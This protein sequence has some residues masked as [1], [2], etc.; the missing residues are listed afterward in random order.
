MG[1]EQIF[2]PFI[3]MLVLTFCVWLLMYRRRINYIVAN[4]IRPSQLKTPEQLQSLLPDEVSYPSYNLKNLFEL[5]VVFYAL[6]VYL[7]VTGQADMIYTVAAWLF[8]LLRCGHSFVHCTSNHV[9]TR[10]RFYA[11]S[12]IVLWLML[13][14]A[15]LQLVI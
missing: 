5:P 14:R 10:F 2:M 9:M 1:P 12:S 6:V 8:F 15:V 13:G 7:Y 11:A 4:R 3:G